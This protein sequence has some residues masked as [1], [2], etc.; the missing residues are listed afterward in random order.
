MRRHKKREKKLMGK[1]KND[2][3]QAN[4]R[5]ENSQAIRCCACHQF[6]RIPVTNIGVGVSRV[7]GGGIKRAVHV[8]LQQKFSAT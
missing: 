4:A 1:F 2:S 8:K 3:T 6:V 5:L 7:T